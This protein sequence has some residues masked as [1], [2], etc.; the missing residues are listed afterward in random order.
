MGGELCQPAPGWAW[1]RVALIVLGIVLFLSLLSKWTFDAGRT[2][3]RYTV[4]RVK[5]LIRD[6]IH[7]NAT[8]AQDANPLLALVHATYSLAY[9]NTARH[10]VSDKD[11]VRAKGPVNPLT[12]QPVH[13][14]KIQGGIRLGQHIGNHPIG[15]TRHRLRQTTAQPKAIQF[16]KIQHTQQSRIQ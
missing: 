7:W 9:L 12:R 8:S 13:G 1:G 15:H 5:S 14:R 2:Y 10:M 16:L 4:R 6:A 11:Q 3:P